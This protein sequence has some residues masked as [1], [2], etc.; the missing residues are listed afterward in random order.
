MFRSQGPVAAEPVVGGGCVS[1]PS[2]I[3]PWIATGRLRCLQYHARSRRPDRASLPASVTTVTFPTSLADLEAMALP[4]IVF[5][6]D[7]KITALNTAAMRLGSGPQARPRHDVI[8]KYAS[9]YAPGIEYL[10]AERVAA[11][12]SPDGAMFEI[13]I[14]TRRGAHMLE[15]VVKVYE[16]DGQLAVVVVVTSA[17]PLT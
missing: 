16:L 2:M 9:E 1:R 11:G 15:H 17:R 3:Q 13:A 7:G 4:T 14:K 5:D 6:L 12:R 8:G 10:W